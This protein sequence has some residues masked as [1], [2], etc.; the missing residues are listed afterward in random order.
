MKKQLLTLLIAVVGFKCYAQ[1]DL[2][3]EIRRAL[4]NDTVVLAIEHHQFNYGNGK[5]KLEG[6]SYL[7]HYDTY[8]PKTRLPGTIWRR[9]GIWKNYRRN[10]QLKRKEVVALGDTATN[11]TSYYSKDGT[12]YLKKFEKPIWNRQRVS[13]NFEYDIQFPPRFHFEDYYPNGQLKK[14]GL[15]VGIR[16]QGECIAYHENGN[17]FYRCFYDENGRFKGKYVVHHPN[18]NVFQQYYYD[19]SNRLSGEYK[20]YYD[21]TKPK[22]YGQYAH[23]RK[24]GDW[25][26]YDE[27][28]EIKEKKTFANPDSSK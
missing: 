16:L 18:G 23:G 7:S 22:T 13:Q 12:L 27:T 26:W 25:V 5:L 20:A 28:G 11:I 10:G 24:V 9:I 3:S 1:I 21:N 4:E 15:Q 19:E 14:T 2:D 17:L 8:P 6:W